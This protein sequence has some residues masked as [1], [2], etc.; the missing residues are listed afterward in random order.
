M[1][2]IYGNAK[3]FSENSAPYNAFTDAYWSAQQAAVNPRCI[4]KPSKDIEVSAL[5]PVSRL[6][7]CPFAVKAGGHTAFAG[8]SGIEGG[9]TVALEDM[10]AITVSSDK[11][12]ASVG[13][14]NVWLKVYQT[15]EQSGVAVVGG[16]VSRPTRCKPLSSQLP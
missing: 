6:T 4:F 10:N 14:G 11:K 13:S 3:L 15:L 5:V 12:V 1:N 16:R 2:F 7:Q 8:G 9:I